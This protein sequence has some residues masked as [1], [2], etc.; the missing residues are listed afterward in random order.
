MRERHLALLRCWRDGLFQATGGLLTAPAPIW[1]GGAPEHRRDV[2]IRPALS[3]PFADGASVGGA[4]SIGGRTELHARAADESR[5]V[6][7]L[8][9]STSQDKLE[10]DLLGPFL[11]HLALAA[12]AEDSTS[13]PTRAIVIRPEKDGTPSIDVRLFLAISSERARAYLGALAS[14]L[15]RQVHPYFLPCEG[16]FFWK[17]HS[18][19]GETIGVRQ[20]ILLLRDDNWTRFASDHGPIPDPR[21]YPVPPEAEAREMVAR[22]FQP[23]FEA[24]APQ[25]P[26]PKKKRR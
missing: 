7:S 14:E 5:V 4:L 13:R 6:V 8:A 12:L 16:V 2:V 24:F 25:D 11:T 10:R 26:P 15:L 18:D 1:L 17:D 9:A 21:D 23:Y 3:V 22:R 19:K 20:S